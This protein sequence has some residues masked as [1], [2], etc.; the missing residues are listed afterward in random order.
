MEVVLASQVG[1]ISG[2]R[3]WQKTRKL[4]VGM[5]VGVNVKGIQLKMSGIIHGVYLPRYLGT[6]R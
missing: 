6:Y 3:I 1:K 4:L 2:Q 5:A